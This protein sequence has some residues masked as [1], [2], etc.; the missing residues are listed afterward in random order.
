[1]G[2]NSEHVV[3]FMGLALRDISAVQFVKGDDDPKD[4]PDW[5]KSSP[6]GIMHGEDLM[7]IW[8]M[9]LPEEKESVDDSDPKGKGKAKAIGPQN[10][11]KIVPPVDNS[12]SEEVKP[13]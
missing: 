6:L 13:E 10:K 1:M 3:L 7:S 8:R 4:Y 2:S 12:S 5:V 9:Q 11:R